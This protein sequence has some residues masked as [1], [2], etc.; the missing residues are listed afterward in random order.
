M[1]KVQAKDRIFKLREELNAHNHHYYVLAQPVISDFEFD[2]LMQELMELEK[3]FPEF[4]DENSPSMRVGSDIN[5]EFEQVKHRFPMMSLGI[6]MQ[7]SEK[8]LPGNSNMFV[9]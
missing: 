1:D 7:E 8:S 3:Q 2:R 4:N 6:L 9:N 5:L